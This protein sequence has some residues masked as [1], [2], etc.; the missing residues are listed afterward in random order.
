MSEAGWQVIALISITLHSILLANF[1]AAFLKPRSAKVHPFVAYAG[2]GLA[3][4][5]GKYFLAYLSVARGAQG[6][7][8]LMSELVFSLGAA[9]ISLIMV[10]WL[11][12]IFFPSNPGM[13]VFLACS[14]SAVRE[15]THYITNGIYNLYWFQFLLERFFPLNIAVDIALNTAICFF[16]LQNITKNLSYRRHAFNLS[17]LLYLILPCL[18][19]LALVAVIQILPYK[20]GLTGRWE[21]TLAIPYYE[22]LI[23]L[24]GFIF[25]FSLTSTVK[26]F[27]QMDELR[28]DER[29]RMLLS[30]QTQQIQ[31]QVRDVNSIY[32]E[33]RSMRHDIRSHISN[34][35]LLVEAVLA[36][37]SDLKKDLEQYFGEL[38]GTL[39]NL[40]FAF[41]TENP[42][43]D[44]IIQ[45]K[46]LEAQNQGI[47][48]AADFIY[49]ARLKIDVYDLAVILNNALENAIEANLLLPRANRSISLYSYLK[50]AM[51]F[52]EVENN[53]AG[54]ITL[55][56]YTNLPASTKAD[57]S[58]HGIGLANIQRCARKY[59]GEIDVQIAPGKNIFL[60]TIM[61]QGEN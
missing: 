22:F 45:Q 26:L 18:S 6:P 20:I 33:I 41:K 46:Y 47:K 1:Y 15:I 59:H 34:L 17:E 5:S 51:F 9:F 50:G 32:S 13:R 56:E 10:Y 55:N 25:L 40:D 44:V 39:N 19:G 60:L 27:R 14:F 61:L 8:D 7:E 29:E 49:P 28:M 12:F 24:A 21:T 36:G 57:K 4:L 30:Q 54:K 52:I 16:A 38:A 42:I 43:T 35:Q 31:E 53:F 11:S 3:H 23:P 2:F 37:R 58:A 48:F